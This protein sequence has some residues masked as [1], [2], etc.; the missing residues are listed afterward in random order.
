MNSDRFMLLVI[1][2]NLF[3]SV[4]HFSQGHIDA[5][6]GWGCA[7]LWAMRVHFIEGKLNKR[8]GE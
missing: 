8:E 3:C 1:F 6:A 5:G 4:L 7:T 2:A